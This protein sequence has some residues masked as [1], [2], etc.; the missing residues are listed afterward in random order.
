VRKAL[1]GC[2]L[3]VLGA[4]RAQTRHRNKKTRIE[5][6]FFVCKSAICKEIVVA[7]GGIEPSAL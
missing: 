7:R 5:A 4:K 3:L 2:R 1:V 6:G